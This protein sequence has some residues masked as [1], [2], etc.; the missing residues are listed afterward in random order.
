MNPA[1]A[2]FFT[3]EKCCPHLHRLRA[4]CQSCNH[5]S[6]ICD[7][8]RSYHGRVNH[9]DNPRNERKS[10]RHR[11]LR[12]T[13]ERT[14]MSTCFEA[15][16]HDGINPSLLKRDCLIRRGR[17]SNRQDAFR[18]TLVKDF[19]WRNSEYEAEDGYFFLQ[20]NASLIF[21]SDGRVWFVLWTRRL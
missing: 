20:Q 16:R 18:S 10:T 12:S 21:E 14:T 4:E 5:A 19:F 1:R 9:V 6:R 15:G 7:P 3:R 8:A 11:I 2:R 13:K 17:S